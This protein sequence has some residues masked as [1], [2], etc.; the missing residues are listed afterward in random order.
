[1]KAIH[2]TNNYDVNYEI[3]EILKNPISEK[4]QLAEI[5]Y[6]S[7]TYMTGGILIPYDELVCKVLDSLS[8]E[9]Q[10][11]L[12]KAIKFSNNKV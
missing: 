10:Y 1:M 2:R 7:K 9:E 6:K 8:Y 3:V 12:L 4:N 11:K 5:R